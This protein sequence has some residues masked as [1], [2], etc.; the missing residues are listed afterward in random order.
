MVIQCSL[1]LVQFKIIIDEEKK[2]DNNLYEKAI[3]FFI[4]N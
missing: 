4:A 2:T 1:K 3:R